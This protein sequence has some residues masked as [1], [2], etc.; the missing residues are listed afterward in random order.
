MN[1]DLPYLHLDKAGI[2]TDGLASCEALSLDFD[3]VL[4]NTLTSYAPDEQ[5]RSL[6]TTG[7]DVER[8]LAFHDIGRVD[9]V[10][11][12]EAWETVLSNALELRAAHEEGTA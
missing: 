2:L 4:G 9:P 8:I 10:P 3:T 7:A 5:G 12:V 1:F 6:G 11:Y